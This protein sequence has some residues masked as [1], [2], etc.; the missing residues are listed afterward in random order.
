MYHC[1]ICGS[2]ADIHHIIHKHEGGYDIK[3]NYKY[4]CNYHHR[5][6]IG[7]HHCIETDLKYKLEM[8]E[9]LFNLLPKDYYTAKELYGLLEITTSSLKKLV[10]NLKLYKEGYCKNEIIKRLMGGKIYSSNILDELELERLYHTINI[11]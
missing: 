2:K 8:Q 5:G 9:K 6:K 7:P 10:K 4:L 3:L 11:S 1:E